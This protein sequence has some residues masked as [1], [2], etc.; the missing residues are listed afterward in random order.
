MTLNTYIVVVKS[1]VVQ[2][3]LRY[4]NGN[5]NLLKK[6]MFIG[7]FDSIEIYYGTHKAI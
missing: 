6:T 1:M 3:L 5:S 4:V 7:T 2:I